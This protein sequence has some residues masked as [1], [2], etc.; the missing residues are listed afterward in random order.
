MIRARHL[1]PTLMVALLTLPAAADEVVRAGGEFVVNAT[2]SSDQGFPHVGTNGN[3]EFVVTWE[4]YGQDGDYF[5]VFGQQLDAA[6]QPVGGEFPVNTTTTANQWDPAVAVRED[7][8]FVITWASFLQDG[9]G[10]GVFARRFDAAGMAVGGEIAVNSHTPA[11]QD[12]PDIAAGPDGGFLIVW[13]SAG[14]DM[15]FDG[16]YAQRYD[17]AGMA[18][19]DEFR[20]NTTTLEEQDEAQVAAVS[21]GY[22]VVWESGGIDTSGDAVMI[23]RLDAS[24]NAVGDETQINTTFSNDQEDPDVAVLPDGTYAVVWES[25]G[26]DGDGESVAGQVFASDGTAIGSEM[27]LNQTITGNQDDPRIAAVG[28]DTFLVV[29]TSAAPGPS[30]ADVFGRQVSATGDPVGDEF[31]INTS[32]DAP[33][34]VPSV[35]GDPAGRAIA[36]WRAFGDHDGDAAG[37]LGQGF[38]LAFFFGGFEGGNTMEWTTSVG[39]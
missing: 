39:E 11:D 28:D 31:R 14:Q 18:A 30:V 1:C 3:G 24:G 6:G 19:G 29:W 10:Y 13:E 15:S 33:Q 32:I 27:L 17:A 25:D 7:G 35:A 26:Q 9:D 23:Q 21:D 34:D 16:V 4:S 37:V 12:F 20:V 36:A 5:G 38:D 22:L 2:T 8:S